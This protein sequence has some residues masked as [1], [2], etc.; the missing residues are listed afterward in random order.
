MNVNLYFYYAIHNSVN[1]LIIVG[2][3]ALFLRKINK[4]TKKLKR[5]KR[6]EKFVFILKM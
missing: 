2:K 1:K 5:K 3:K 4:F 6:I